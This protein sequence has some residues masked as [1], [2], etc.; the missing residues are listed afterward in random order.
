MAARIATPPTA[1]NFPNN[2]AS[3]NIGHPRN[4]FMSSRYAKP[5]A[6]SVVTEVPKPI[7]SGSGVACS[8]LLA[9]PNI[10]LSGFDHHHDGHAQRDAASGTALLRGKLRINVSK[11]IKIKAVQ[12]KLLGRARTEWPEG[13]PPLKQDVFEEESLRT[14]VLT[15]FNAMYD[16]WETEYGNQCQYKLKSSSANSSSTNLTASVLA[17]AA[18][19][20]SVAT[21]R[22]NLAPPSLTAKDLKRLSLQNAQSRSFGNIGDM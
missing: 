14:Q 7:A 18:L 3:P 1:Y 17:S 15:F 21:S 19:G 10:F 13:I 2:A 8:I 20:P 5:S 9:E 4:S 22:G 12:L 6:S 16:G 11:N